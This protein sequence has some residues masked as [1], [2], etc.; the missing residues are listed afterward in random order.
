MM[1]RLAQVVSKAAQAYACN[2]ERPSEVSARKD[3]VR[4]WNEFRLGRCPF[5]CVGY[6]HALADPAMYTWA[7][8]LFPTTENRVF[9][10]EYTRSPAYL[11]TQIRDRSRVVEII[12]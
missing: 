9:T 5:P 2:E 4:V 1:E 12:K 6:Q 7:Y 10:V 3:S 8:L 11:R